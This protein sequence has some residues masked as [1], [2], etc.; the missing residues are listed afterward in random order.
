MSGLFKQLWSIFALL[1]LPL[2]LAGSVF[3]PDASRLLGSI[4]LLLGTGLAVYLTVQKH[5]LALRQGRVS[6]KNVLGGLARDLAGLLVTLAAAMF[7]GSWAG[8]AVSQAVWQA[9]GRLWLAML[10]GLAAG[11]AAGFGTGWLVRLSWRWLFRLRRQ[12][13][14]GPE[15]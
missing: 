15:N 2:I 9:T 7:S 13:D 14:P 1:L 8:L 5:W 10:I 12:A 4:S 3:L 11:F 6:Q